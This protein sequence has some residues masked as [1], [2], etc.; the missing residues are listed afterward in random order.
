M[1]DQNHEERLSMFEQCA[2]TLQV[3]QQVSHKLYRAYS[4]RLTP[5]IFTYEGTIFETRTPKI[6]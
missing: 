1:T 5:K 2:Q 4:Q 6:A 3:H